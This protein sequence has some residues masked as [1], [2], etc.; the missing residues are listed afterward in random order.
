MD[1]RYG[2]PR[3]NLERAACMRIFAC[4]AVHASVRDDSADNTISARAFHSP[5]S[6]DIDGN[7][8]LVRVHPAE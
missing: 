4:E 6:E 2:Y 1:V 8:E 7:L 3:E 5:C